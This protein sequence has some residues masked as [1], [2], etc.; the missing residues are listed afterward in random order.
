MNKALYIMLETTCLADIA[1]ANLSLH[2]L[3]EKSVGIGD[4]STNDFY[5]NADEA[6]TKLAEAKDKLECL[7]KN[8]KPKK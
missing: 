8:F 5:N 4:H 7:H 1:K 2:L 6:L 3:G